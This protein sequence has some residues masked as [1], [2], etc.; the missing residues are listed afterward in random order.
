MKNSKNKKAVKRL[1]IKRKIRSKISGSASLP[2]LSVFKSNK[3]IYAQIIDDESMKTIVS[4]ND[5]KSKTKGK[6][7]RA[8]E[9]GSAIASEAVKAGIKKVVFD[10]NG[11]KFIGRV[12]SLATGAREGGLEL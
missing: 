8:K 6:N 7:D 9:V 5:S 1:R 4:S 3:F 2:R 10:R 11:Y 12:S